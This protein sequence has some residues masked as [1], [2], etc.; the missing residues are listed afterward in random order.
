LPVTGHLAF[1]ATCRLNQLRRDLLSDQVAAFLVFRPRR[2]FVVSR[3]STKGSASGGVLVRRYDFLVKA[4]V[5]RYRDSPEP[6]EDL[7][8]VGYLGLIKAIANFDP[9]L[10]PGLIAYAR[11]CVDG[12]LKRHFRDKRWQVHVNRASQ[13]LML[14]VRAARSVLTQELGRAP[15]DQEIAEALGV[16]A[17]DLKWAQQAEMAFRPHV[18]RLLDAALNRLREC[19]TG[20]RK[21]RP[22]RSRRAAAAPLPNRPRADRKGRELPEGAVS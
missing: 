13:E 21:A 2:S 20:V 5:R 17:D 19:L 8:Q 15:R 3:I 6:E 11:P 22:R 7:M 10:G 9:E 12:E 18:S 1:P 16:S 14:E 4:C